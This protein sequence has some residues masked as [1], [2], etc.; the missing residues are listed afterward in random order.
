[1]LSFI[2]NNV[3]LIG[4]II[5]IFFSG[6]LFT[7]SVFFGKN[8]NENKESKNI[9]ELLTQSAAT[10]GNKVF[11][12]NQQFRSI[13][14]YYDNQRNK[15]HPQNIELAKYQQF[16]ALSNQAIIQSFARESDYKI[17]QKEIDVE[18]DQILISQNLK[19]KKELKSK[20]KE[21]N[22]QYKQFINSIKNSIKQDKFIE[23][24]QSNIHVSN[25]D[26]ENK[27]TELKISHILLEV[28][29][30]KLA[31]SQNILANEVYKKVRKGG[32]FSKLAIKYSDD[33]SVK[34]NKGN[35][36][37]VSYGQTVPD[38]QD[39][40]YT[41]E[42]DEVSKPFLTE[43]GYH[44]VKLNKKRSKV[45]PK[46]FNLENEK[47]TMLKE[48][49][50][51]AIQEFLTKFVK[52]N[53]L[54]IF[55][56]ELNAI[57]AKVNRNLELA[58]GFYQKIISK[59]PNDPLPNFYLAQIFLFQKKNDLALQE[60]EKGDIKAELSPNLDFK[61]I[62]YELY[63]IYK[64]KKLK[65]NAINQLDKIYA[66]T[67]N[68]ISTLKDLK[69]KYDDMKKDDMKKE[70]EKKIVEIETK[71]KEE[72]KKKEV[73]NAEEAKNKELISKKVDD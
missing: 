7:T 55:D 38:F 42:E 65:A 16:L 68:D 61:E 17:N 15:M 24:L 31:P 59:N 33:P 34:N 19:D 26:V 20:L 22:I 3:A 11:I 52:S 39:V 35:L 60:L 27:Y 4:W 29:D 50:E 53:K 49:K 47:E 67:D 18:L 73:S 43:F 8:Y 66:L 41:L 48:K 56:D 30:S 21:N 6:T 69:E 36:G 5:I 32:N 28:N 58:L 12:S 10:Y 46:D 13:V 63:K 44:I 54:E 71:L 14:N 9:S 51:L 37:W 64:N 25:S 23:D 45:K 72:K 1:M 2:R 40:A 70:I 57:H 62:H